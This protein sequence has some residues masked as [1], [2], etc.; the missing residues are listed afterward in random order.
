MKKAIFVLLM[1]GPGTLC[2]A[3][4]ARQ[5]ATDRLDNARVRLF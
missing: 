1:F 2:W 4:S 3:G 5:D